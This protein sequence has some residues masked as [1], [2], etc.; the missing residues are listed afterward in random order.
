MTKVFFNFHTH[1]PPVH[2]DEMGILNIRASQP[3]QQ[4]PDH[5]PV[6]VGIH[7]WDVHLD[8][9]N[10]QWEYVQ[11]TAAL[12]Q[13]WTIGETG[14]DRLATAPL[15]M[16]AEVFRQQVLLA[17]QLQKPLIIHCVRAFPELISMKKS[18]Q[19]TIPWIIHGYNNNLTLATQL[20]AHDFYFSF[21]TALLQP[22]SQASQVLTTGAKE[23]FFLETDDKNLSIKALYLCAAQR[24]NGSEESLHQQVHKRLQKIFPERIGEW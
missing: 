22:D 15:H 24:V 7:P 17:Q 14:L 11:Q 12:P 6:S 5:Q 10:E 21:G 23:R 18:I 1:H 13:V 2:S 20:L 8:N 9:L 3:V 19:T 4:L 16:Q